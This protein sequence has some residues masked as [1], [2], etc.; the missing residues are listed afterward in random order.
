LENIGKNVKELSKKWRELEIV[1]SGVWRV[2]WRVESGVES[3]E[4]WN[5]KI[6]G[7]IKMN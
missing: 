1:E 3:G 5:W 2:E 7:K 6:L 4:N